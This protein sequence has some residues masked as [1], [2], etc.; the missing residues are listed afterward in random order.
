MV[1][2]WGPASLSPEREGA[3]TF[4]ILRDIHDILGTTKSHFWACLETTGAE[5]KGFASTILAPSDEGGT[6]NL[7][8]EF[9]PILSMRATGLNAYYYT[10]DNNRHLVAADNADYSYEG[11]AEP[12]SLGI[13]ALPMEG[14]SALQTLIAKYDE[15]VATEYSFHITSGDVLQLDL[16]DGIDG[17]TGDLRAT[18][19]V[20]VDLH[21]MRF[22]VVT[23]AGAEGTVTFYKD[24]EQQNA[25]D[26]VTPTETNSFVNMDDTAAKFF[27]G[28]RD[29][30]G[31]PDDLF[32]GWLSQPFV[33]GK[34]LTSTE[35]RDLYQLWRS[36]VGV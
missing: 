9:T 18:S 27:V 6:V 33:T 22:Y 12:F 11:A 31:A 8:D 32:E 24:G 30:G 20:S 2:Q 34:A 4:G 35:V 19:T 26:T 10:G 25:A 3:A 17:A 29:D 23:Y 5:V 13:W 14:G 28:G 36:V 1:T 7:E 21:E 16:Y 15:G